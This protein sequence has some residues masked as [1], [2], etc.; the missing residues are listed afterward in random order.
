MRKGKGTRGETQRV[1]GRVRNHV[2]VVGGKKE[3]YEGK[4]KRREGVKTKERIGSEGEVHGWQG[5]AKEGE[6]A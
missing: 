6:R 5:G 2:R 3:S 1:G 4:S